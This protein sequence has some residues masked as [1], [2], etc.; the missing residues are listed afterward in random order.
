[1]KKDGPNKMNGQRRWKPHLKR[2]GPQTASFTTLCR[3]EINR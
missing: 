2:R 3:Q 1:M